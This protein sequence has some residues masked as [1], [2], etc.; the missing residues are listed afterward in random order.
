MGRG[1]G[2]GGRSSGGGG[3]RSSGG[4]MSS[5]GRGGY[6]SSSSG[7]YHGSGG[8]G[9]YI[10]CE[11]FERVKE[12]I[13]TLFWIG[14]I[15]FLILHTIDANR[16]TISTRNREPLEKGSV[17]E[18]EYYTD[19]LGWIR[20]SST[21]ESGMKE[22]YEKT[23]VQPYLFITDYVGTSGKPT[24]EDFDNYA[25]SLYDVLFE[26]EAHVLVLFYEKNSDGNYVTWYV[27]G[28]Q[29]KT[30]V[31][32]EGADI[33]LDYIDKYYYSDHD[34][35]EMFSRAFKYAASRM[36]VKTISPLFIVLVLLGIITV[37]LILYFWWKAFVYQKNKEAEQ[38][39]RIL[40][41]DIN[42]I[43]SSPELQELEDK[44]D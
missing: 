38:T 41:A 21:L 18:T 4:R 7:G 19:Q 33:L 26:D 5:S 3:G 11:P 23:G 34:E 31:D 28:K 29:A 16:I 24:E 20:S 39:A 12:A 36:M 25:N 30:V 32:K 8:G 17:I 35:D 42:T 13:S 14:C 2:G 10:Y 37:I 44:Y 6:S 22:F 27:A 9:G 40:N 43:S 15:I 1:G